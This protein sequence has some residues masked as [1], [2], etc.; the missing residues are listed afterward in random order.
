MLS[1]MFAQ[2]NLPNIEYYQS[3]TAVLV[4]RIEVNPF[5]MIRNRD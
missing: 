3:I 1:C 4:E 2:V 5:D